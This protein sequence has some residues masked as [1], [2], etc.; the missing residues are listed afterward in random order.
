MGGN[1]PLRHS[2]TQMPPPPLCF[3]KMGR[4]NSF[5]ILPIFTAGANGEQPSCY[6]VH[7]WLFLTMALR[8]QMSLRMMAM[9]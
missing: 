8:A 1:K 2:L 9:R 3:V 4:I 6:A 5:K 7:G